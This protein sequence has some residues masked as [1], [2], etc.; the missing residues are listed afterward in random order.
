MGSCCTSFKSC[1]SIVRR[2]TRLYLARTP[3]SGAH[4]SRRRCCLAR[5]YP[6]SPTPPRRRKNRILPKRRHTRM[7]AISATSRACHHCSP[8][9]FKKPLTAHRPLPLSTRPARRSHPEI[10]LVLC[11]HQAPCRLRFPGAD[12]RPLT[13]GPPRPPPPS[14]PSR[15]A[16][17]SALR[18]AR[19]LYRR[20]RYKCPLVRRTMSCFSR[21]QRTTSTK[22]PRSRLCANG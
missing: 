21:R 18:K 13:A 2:L 14:R 19:S 3:V 15:P 9:T 22:T 7:A 12:G 4:R 20:R 6:N 17:L 11:L 5:P 10:P 1:S 8:S 16:A